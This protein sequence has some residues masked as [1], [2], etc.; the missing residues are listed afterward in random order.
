MNSAIPPRL[1]L[2]EDDEIVG[3]ALADRF[4]LEGFACDWYRSGGEALLEI[5]RRHYDLVLS[6]IRLPDLSGE[7]LFTS[8]SR[9]MT[10][11]P[12]YLFITGYGEIDQAVRL[13]KLGA[14]PVGST[15]E[16]LA[17]MVKTENIKWAKVIK[18]AG[19]K[20]E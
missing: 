5:Q 10:P 3:E 14:E 12:P 17:T 9:E 19:V 8:L 4:E 20:I 11:L 16:Q 7:A 13:L 18:D 6:D 1:C 15:P 2:I